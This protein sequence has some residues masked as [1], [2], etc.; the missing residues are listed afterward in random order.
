[1]K[2]QPIVLNASAV[3][4]KTASSWGLT[5]QRP[6][7]TAVV[8]VSLLLAACAAP[9]RPKVPL[10]TPAEVHAQL[11]QL[12]PADLADRA[13]WATDI[14]APFRLLDIPPSTENLCAA[15]AVI[16]QETGYDA[17][18]EVPGLPR[19]ARAE[20]DRRAASLKIPAL[21]VDAA[22]KLKARDG[23][24]YA[25]HLA[26][27]RSERELSEL[28]EEFIGRV[29]LGGRLFGD[30]NPVRTGGPM[31][32]SIDF[33]QRHAR[34]RGYPYAPDASIR[35]EVFTRR[36]GLYFGIAHLLDYPNSYQRHLYRYADFNA[37]WYASRNAAFQA[38]A[39]R[40]SGLPRRA[41]SASRSRVGVV[42]P[43]RWAAVSATA[44]GRSSAFDGMQ[45]Q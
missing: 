3:I 44:S 27:V 23:R 9:P 5:A 17:D 45:A 18:A 4:A 35:S 26:T 1:M 42:M 10:R 29:P 11:L 8:L 41:S 31:Q 32:V 20:I 16:A 39:S 13:G 6:M 33:A 40:V 25:Q 7:R 15:M 14:Q 2:E 37:G 19:I 38:A 43:S 36:G 22:L 28:F 21:A 24:S 30:A 34:S 12:L